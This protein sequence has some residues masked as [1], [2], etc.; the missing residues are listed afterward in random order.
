MKKG[1]AVKQLKLHVVS[2]LRFKTGFLLAAFKIHGALFARAQG[3]GTRRVLLII[4]L[5]EAMNNADSG[6]N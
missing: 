6:W 3:S 4:T 5:P 2:R 1:T